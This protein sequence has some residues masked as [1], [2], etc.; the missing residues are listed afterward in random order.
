[1]NT[2]HLQSEKSDA[3]AQATSWLTLVDAG[4]STET[5]RAVGAVLRDGISAEKWAEEVERVQTSLGPLT[6]RTMAVE[7]RLDTLPGL[8]EGDYI[9][10]QYHS[11]YSEIRAVVETLTL[12]RE[13]DS[14]WRVVGYFVR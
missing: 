13:S 4:K 10:R 9:V 6:S 2:L 12:Q 5:W 1:M 14:V 7:Q 11:I 3:D 8:P